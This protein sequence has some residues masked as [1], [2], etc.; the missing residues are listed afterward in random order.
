MS[1]DT[2]FGPVALLYTLCSALLAGLSLFVIL[3]GRRPPRTRAPLR[4]AFF[5]L[6]PC[7]LVWILALFLGVRTALP[8]AQLWVGRANF[9]A[10]AVAATL[11]LRFVQEVP[12]KD[13]ASG[14]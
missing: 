11:A 9:T 6:A 5:L 3:R 8:A 1:S 10:V 2:L 4:W 7:L 14:A 13:R 12:R